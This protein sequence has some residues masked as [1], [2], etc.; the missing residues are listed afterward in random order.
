M[1]ISDFIGEAVSSGKL[2]THRSVQRKEGLGSQS[3]TL[4]A[5]EGK[6][7]ADFLAA[8]LPEI[9]GPLLT[10]KFLYESDWWAVSD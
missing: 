3:G 2:K 8:T 10:S 4:S 6:V 9:L 7:A 1:R 5:R